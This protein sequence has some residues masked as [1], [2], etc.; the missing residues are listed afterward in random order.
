MSKPS[1]PAT[2]RYVERISQPVSRS[3][4]PFWRTLGPHVYCPIC[5]ERLRAEYERLVETR[6]VY[7]DYLTPLVPMRRAPVEALPHSDEHV[8]VWIG[9]CSSCGQ[10]VWSD[11]PPLTRAEIAAAREEERQ[12]QLARR[13]ADRLE[14][15]EQRAARA[16]ARVCKREGH[17]LGSP[18][19]LSFAVM[20]VEHGPVRTCER[21]G[22]MVAASELRAV[23]VLLE[24]HE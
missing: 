5:E 7:I 23:D 2:W 3:R 22:Q 10:V 15:A 14:R 19:I 13:E 11:R 18:V 1:L 21:C 4:N 16:R 20:G 9:A 24:E 8:E 6:G 17:R 12:A